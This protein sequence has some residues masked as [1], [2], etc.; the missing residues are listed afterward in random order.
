MKS[1]RRGFL[2]GMVAL[3]FLGYFAFAF[4]KNITNELNPQSKDFKITLG[5]EQLDAP[6]QKLFPPT[7]NASNRIRFGLI[8]NGWRGDQLLESFGFIHPEKVMANTVNGKYSEWL[9][10]FI[11]QEDLNVEFGGICDT[12][13]IHANRGVEISL[14]DI[15]PGGLK[16]NTK[17]AKVFPSY[18]EMIASPEIDAIVIATPD[19]THAKIAIEAAKA[20]KH[21]Y[22]EKPM[23]HS[24]EEAIDLRNTIKSTGVVFQL[25]HENRQQMSFKMARELYQKGVLGTVSMVQTYTNRNS[26]DGAWIR[27]RKFDH[28]G[29]ISNINWKEFLGNAP[30][31]EFDPKR[32]FN[33]HRY[34]DYGTSVTGNDFS[35]K[36]DCVNQVLDLGIPETVVALGGQYYYKNHGDMPDVINA[37]FSYPQKGLTMTYDGTLKNGIYRQSH[38]L[39]SEATI[40]IDN[41]IMLYKDSN[42]ER[43]KDIEIDPSTPLYYYAPNADVDAVT[44]ATAKTY[45][46]GGYGPTFIDG[47]IID[48][49]FLHIKEWIDAIRGHGKTSCNI[50]VG[51]EESV[52]F[53][54]AN[55]AYVHKKPVNW[56][57]VKEKASIA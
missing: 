12:F 21:I 54:L 8:G 15:R 28:L 34:S 27:T 32:Y 57:K 23:T 46:K 24:I 11:R 13:E 29:N 7:G 55:L 6:G 38:I 26:L 5:I 39:G 48:A 2:K 35:H 52:T 37:I 36:F 9:N 33:W 56:D 51:F 43:Y 3:P 16:G 42:S 53:N 50:D 20:G 22:L 30:W 1:D 4:K 47:K 31:H 19:H 17:P 18:R 49:T 14:N 10:S 44:S 41:A 25:G 45:L 40:D